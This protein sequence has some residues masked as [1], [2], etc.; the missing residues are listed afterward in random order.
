MV[1]MDHKAN[2]VL[3]FIFVYASSISSL[4][5]C[6]KNLLVYPQVF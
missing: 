1:G 4:Y 2:S 5:S 6:E 3:A